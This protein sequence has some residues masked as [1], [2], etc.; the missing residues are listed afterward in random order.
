MS[1]D[2]TI[3]HNNVT[4]EYVFVGHAM[5]LVYAIQNQFQ[6]DFKP[7]DSII[8]QKM[9]FKKKIG[10]K[11]KLTSMFVNL[12]LKTLMTGNDGLMFSSTFWSISSSWQSLMIT[13]ICFLWR[14]DYIFTACNFFCS[15][16]NSRSKTMN[17]WSHLT[18]KKCW[19]TRQWDECFLFYG[20]SCGFVNYTNE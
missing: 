7:R 9:V 8:I 18:V 11:I 5:I 3:L 2:D 6:A 1:L 20:F 13:K 12:W 15:S 17:F 4:L 19:E 10:C 14:L 16:S